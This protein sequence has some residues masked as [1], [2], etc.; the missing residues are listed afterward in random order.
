[1]SDGLPL[2]KQ[3]VLNP[4]HNTRYGAFNF[5][6]YRSICIRVS[7]FNLTSGALHSMSISGFPSREYITKSLRFCRVFIVSGC[8]SLMSAAGNAFSR[9]KYCNKCCR[10]NSSGVINNH[11]FLT[12]SNT[13]PS[14]IITGYC[15]KG[16][17]SVMLLNN[18]PVDGF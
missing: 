12:G 17:E 7:S 8:S 14:L 11:F 9:R 3:R 6:L 15:S 4:L 2:W 5:I 18:A 13:L 16:I 1:M 10:T